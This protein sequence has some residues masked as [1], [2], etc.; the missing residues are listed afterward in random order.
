MKKGFIATL[1]AAAVSF[2]GIQ[3]A[4]ALAPV[5]SNIPDIEIG[6]AEAA[7]NPGGTDNNIF[8]FTNAFRFSDKVSDG[9]T[10]DSALLWSFGEF[11]EIGSPIPFDETNGGQGQYEIN[12]VGALY[13]GDDDFV[14]DPTLNNAKTPGVKKINVAAPQNNNNADYASL[15][16]IVYSPLPHNPPYPNRDPYDAAAAAGRSVVYIVS[17]GDNLS[18][19]TSLVKTVDGQLDAISSSF[20]VLVDEIGTWSGWVQSTL[21]APGDV[22]VTNNTTHLSAQ[23]NLHS[24]GGY[25]RVAGWAHRTYADYDAVGTSNYVRTKWYLYASNPSSDPVNRVPNFRIRVSNRDQVASVNEVIY[26]NTGNTG[27]LG[28][29][30]YPSLDNAAIETRAGVDLR[31]S[32]NSLKPS[33]YRL[34]FDPVDVPALAGTKLTVVWETSAFNDPAQG[35]LHMTECI[36]GIYPALTDG[37]GVELLE[38]DRAVADA[39]LTKSGGGFNASNNFEAGRRQEL[40]IGGAN[41]PYATFVSDS[42]GVTLDSVNVADNRFGIMVSNYIRNT[43]T[44]K[45]R[46]QEGKLYRARFHTTSN[47][48]TGQATNNGLDMQGNLRWRLQTAGLV[49]NTRLELASARNSTAAATAQGVEAVADMTLSNQA[50]PGVGSANP[51]FDATIVSGSQDGGWYTVLMNTPL[52]GDIRPE[53]AG[54]IAA[55][56][57]NLSAEPGPG[58]NTAGSFKDIEVGVDIIK[59][60]TTLLVPASIPFTSNPINA[61]TRT[62]KMRLT[63]HNQFDDGGYAY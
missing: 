35:T 31:P 10:A 11:D 1:F 33:L 2:A 49:F 19:T 14:A 39:D 24:G 37:D 45:P 18:S 23:V 28:D 57:P 53:V 8:V 52:D 36:L 46:V 34:D 41:G 54:N 55:K 4:F 25:Y 9:D 21:A 15:R 20:T 32:P 61:N 38:Y 58:V 3:S 27:A 48:A 47:V 42:N 44:L 17:D 6:D 30:P 26:G 59:I 40:F 43:V 50:L 62:E 29:L 7:D 56:M 5:I 63:E 51:D 13:V 22:V 16:D 60:P 12:G